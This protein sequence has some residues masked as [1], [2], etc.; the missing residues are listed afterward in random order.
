M[1][2][3]SP[4]AAA[5]RRGLRR[6]LRTALWRARFVLVAVCC[7]LAATA[8]VHALRPDPPPT[9]DVVVP[10][11]PLVAGERVEAA[12]LTVR[13]VP[14]ELAP[15]GVVTATADAVGRVPAVD[16]PA[17]L[18]LHATLVAGGGVAA[19]APEGTVV[20][21]VLLD[22]AA[23]GLLRPGDRVDLVAVDASVLDPHLEPHLE[24]EGTR[25]AGDGDGT[26]HLARGALVLPG[27]TGAAD[28][29]GASLLGGAVTERNA[30]V[31]LVAVQPEE[32]TALSAASARGVVSAVLVP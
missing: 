10:L 24:A 14:A 17:G 27:V 13:P 20:V 8:T 19:H 5:R 2:T 23:S 4:D 25:P 21:P 30:P 12:D 28:E 16:L 29:G 11:H 32:A 31:T 26:H 9:V 6:R 15:D 1:R 3:D 18:P 22:S 7:G